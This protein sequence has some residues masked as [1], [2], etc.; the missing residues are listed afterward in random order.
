MTH[1]INSTTNLLSRH[2]KNAHSVEKEPKRRERERERES[3]RE[4]ER[5]K[6]TERQRERFTRREL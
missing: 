1:A 4:T 5:E 2:Y 6:E 3:E